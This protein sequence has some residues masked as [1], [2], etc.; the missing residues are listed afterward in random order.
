MSHPLLQAKKPL[1]RFSA[2]QFFEDVLPCLVEVRRDLLRALGGSYAFRVR[3]SG[4]WVIDFSVP[5]V[6]KGLG[7]SPDV[8]VEIDELGFVGLLRGTFDARRA[9]GDGRLRVEGDAKVLKRLASG[10]LP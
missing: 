5:E 3:G 10:L 4:D 2:K 8:L 7:G 6:R 9:K 1:S